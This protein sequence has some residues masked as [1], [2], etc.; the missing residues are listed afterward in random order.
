MFLLFVADFDE[1]ICLISRARMGYK[2]GLHQSKTWGDTE[3]G[4]RDE[5]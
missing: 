4:I 1:E 5:V 3:D 2:F